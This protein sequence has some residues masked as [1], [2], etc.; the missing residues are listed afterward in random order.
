MQ[1]VDA[2]GAVGVGG[3]PF[4]LL[5]VR[6]STWHSR[7]SVGGIAELEP[8][9]NGWWMPMGSGV[10]G[11][12]SRHVCALY[13]HRVSAGPEPDP[14]L[15]RAVDDDSFAHAR[16]HAL[17]GSSPRSP[18]RSS[19]APVFHVVYAPPLCTRE[20]PQHTAAHIASQ[21]AQPLFVSHQEFPGSLS[22]SSR[23]WV[24][25]LGQ[26]LRATDRPTC[27]GRFSRGL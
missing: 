27:F 26:S 3:P 20:T 11:V 18:R 6:C 7:P 23:V 9:A 13:R 25:G 24:L 19:L 17:T 14:C 2:C 15:C 22:G 4:W 21:R 5:S 16:T 10:G 12:T 1:K 8:E